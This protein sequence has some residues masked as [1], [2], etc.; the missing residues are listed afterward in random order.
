MKHLL[1]L[2]TALYIYSAVDISRRAKCRAFKGN[3]GKK[4]NFS[5]Q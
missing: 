5:W 1:G 3:I 4:A 2:S